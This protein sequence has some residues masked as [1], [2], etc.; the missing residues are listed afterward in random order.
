MR[1]SLDSSI[2]VERIVG[3]RTGD[4]GREKD[5]SSIPL[6]YRSGLLGLISLIRTRPD[7]TSFV[8]GAERRKAFSVVRGRC[9][10]AKTHETRSGKRNVAE[11]EHELV[12][13]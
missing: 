12:N 13:S 6:E 2:R 8:S 9:I 11:N 1:V 3:Q 4:E 7:R 5:S 10:R